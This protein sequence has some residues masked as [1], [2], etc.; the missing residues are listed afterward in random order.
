[1][2]PGLLQSLGLQRVGHD[3][4]TELNLK[5]KKKELYIGDADKDIENTVLTMKIVI[6]SW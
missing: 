4:M 2:K 3:W 1:M 6:F 5:M